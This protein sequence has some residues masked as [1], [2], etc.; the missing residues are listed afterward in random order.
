MVNNVISETSVPD[1]VTS[2]TDTEA[3][4]IT[5]IH[6]EKKHQI[7]RLFDQQPSCLSQNLVKTLY[8]WGA[9]RLKRDIPHSILLISVVVT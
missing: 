2:N 9:S 3:V 5:L 1:T 8:L 6:G 4:V 7:K